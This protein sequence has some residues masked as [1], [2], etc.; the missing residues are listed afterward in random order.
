MMTV[1]SM[2]AVQYVL[3][4]PSPTKTVFT[5]LDA[6]NFQDWHSCPQVNS[7]ECFL[8]SSRVLIC[9][10]YVCNRCATLLCPPRRSSS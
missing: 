10:Q 2:S 7:L 4:G 1:C 8:G 5:Q 6:G 9:L 3:E